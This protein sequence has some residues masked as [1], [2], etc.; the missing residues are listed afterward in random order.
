MSST[1]IIIERTCVI[2]ENSLEGMRADADCCSA[3][4]RVAKGRRDAARRKE[5]LA[6]PLD[7]LRKLAPGLGEHA[8]A[9]TTLA[10]LLTALTDALGKVATLTKADRDAK[11][12]EVVELRE[13]AETAEQHA[14]AAREQ[15]RTDIEAAQQRIRTAETG[16]REASRRQGEA[17]RLARQ[18]TQAREDADEQHAADR[19]AWE[20]NVNS[21]RQELAALQAGHTVELAGLRRQLEQTHADAQAGLRTAHAAEVA[22]LREAKEAAERDLATAKATALEDVARARAGAQ[23]AITDAVAD[24]RTARHEADAATQ[25]STVAEQRGRALAQQLTDA[26]VAAAH[27][28]GELTALRGQLEHAGQALA[29]AQAE[30]GRLTAAGTDQAEGP[31]PGP[32]EPPVRS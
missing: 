15:A 18:A 13:L 25:R 28:K 5:E 10:P 1:E 6:E 12:D 4:C 32:Q 29:E 23:Q 8:E 22:R 2:C 7:L 31:P 20:N 27:T 14:E 3:K 30:I 26:T 19:Q 11:G 24:A 16:R 9:L 21:L 17:E